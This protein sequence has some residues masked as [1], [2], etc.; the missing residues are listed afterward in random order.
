MVHTDHQTLKHHT[1]SITLTIQSMG[2]D[3]SIKYKTGGDNIVVDVM[4]RCY[5]AEQVVMSISASWVDAIKERPWPATSS[6]DE[7]KFKK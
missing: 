1:S 3:F 5:E 7:I 2:F 6:M 4:S